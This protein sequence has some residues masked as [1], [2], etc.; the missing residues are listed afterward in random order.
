MVELAER[1]IFSKDIGA[2]WG[3]PNHVEFSGS[4]VTRMHVPARD[5]LVMRISR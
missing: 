4:N 3:S 1:R 2:L 5:G